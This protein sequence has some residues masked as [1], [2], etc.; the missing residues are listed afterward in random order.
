MKR[1][2]I[3]S[4]EMAKK[5]PSSYELQKEKFTEQMDRTFEEKEIQFQE[6]EVKNRYYVVIMSYIEQ[7]QP[8]QSGVVAIIRDMTN[9]HQLDQMK[10]ISLL[11]FL[12]NYVHLSP[13]CKVTQNLLWTA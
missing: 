8:H 6:Y 1:E 9:E 12:M 3:L 2:I 13:Y 5:W 10:K 11:M 4:N 7:F